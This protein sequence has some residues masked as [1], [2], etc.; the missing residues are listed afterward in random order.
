MADYGKHPKSTRSY[1]NKPTPNDDAWSDYHNKPKKVVVSSPGGKKKRDY[2][3]DPPELSNWLAI[4]QV[5]DDFEGQ[6]YDDIADALFDIV[7]EL[8]NIEYTLQELNQ[9]KKEVTK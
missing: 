6:D 7:Q 2:T 8:I 3:P 9:P 4:K 1:Y 5:W